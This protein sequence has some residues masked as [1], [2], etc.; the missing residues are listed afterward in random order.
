[1]WQKSVL[2]GDYTFG[3]SIEMSTNDVISIWPSNNFTIQ[4]NFKWKPLPFM[5]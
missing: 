1:M 2:F 3:T 4:A 5:G